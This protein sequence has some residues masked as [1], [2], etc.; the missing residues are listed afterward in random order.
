MG[1]RI[2]TGLAPVLLALC[3]LVVPAQAAAA[4]GGLDR[5]YG[6]GGTTSVSV[7]R[8]GG[9]IY[10]VGLDRSSART[11]VSITRFIAGQ[12]VG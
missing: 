5:S 6:H 2:A 9:R 12:P 8:S 4:H 1:S 7:R 3:V 11:I 10:A